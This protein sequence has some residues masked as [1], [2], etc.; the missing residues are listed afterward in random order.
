MSN[1]VN[2]SLDGN[3]EGGDGSDSSDSRDSVPSERGYLPLKVR[4]RYA[5]A[6]QTFVAGMY[7]AESENLLLKVMIGSMPEVR[8]TYHELRQDNEDLRKLLRK[9]G[10]AYADCGCA[11][12]SPE[13]HQFVKRDG[14]VGMTVGSLWHIHSIWRFR[15]FIRYS[16]LHSVLSPIWGKKHGS[17]VVDV[18]DIPSIEKAVKYAVKDA[19]KNYCSDDNSRKRLFKS[20]NWLPPACRDV[21]KA[22][23]HWALYHG[24]NWRLDDDLDSFSGGEYIAYAWE[25]RNDYFR[26]WCRGEEIV[27]DMA[28]YFRI[29]KGD[30]EK[31]VKKPKGGLQ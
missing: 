12:L 8:N 6:L 28:D 31:L 23:N 19:I 14:S 5:K 4:R 27:L 24:A 25:V 20:H 11:E 2:E 16:D 17:Y 29:I 3:Q 30:I 9:M 13:S 22:L 7:Y 10:L 21:E 26:R 15:E 1:D 18:V